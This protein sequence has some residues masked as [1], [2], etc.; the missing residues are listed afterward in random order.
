MA[1]CT[2]KNDILKSDKCGY[3]LKQIKELYLA[4]YDDVQ[5]TELGENLNTVASIAMVEGKEFYRI[6]PQKDSASYDDALTLGDGGSKYRVPT[7]TFNIS[8]EYDAD[9]HDTLDALSL[10]RYYVVAR[11]TDDTYVMFGRRTP[12]E[13]SAASLQSAAEATGFNGITVTLTANTDES[14]IPLEQ[15]AIE[16]VLAG[17]VVGA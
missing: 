6:D 2:L 3:S 16:S 5:K 1:I 12:M 14:A 13:A 8:G 10:G 15:A 7:I 9:M 4:N 11:F 17:A